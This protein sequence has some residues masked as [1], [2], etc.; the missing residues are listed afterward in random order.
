MRA[1]ISAWS[2]SGMRLEGTSPS[3]CTSIRIVSSTKSGLPSVFSSTR[4][5]HVG[6][7]LSLGEQCGDELLALGRRQRLELD[8]GRPQ[9]PAAPARPHVEQLGACEAD[10]QERRRAHPGGEV[11]DQLEERLLGPVDVLEHEHER[12]RLRE[13][14]GPLA[15]GPRDL[16]LAPLAADRLE[17]ARR[18]ARAGRRPP[19]PRRTRA[20]SRRPRP[21]GSSS[22]IPTAVLTISASGQYVIP[23]P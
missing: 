11:L 9:P 15:H 23:S 18:R 4:L 17:H 16:L 14:L 5:E 22:A 19:R 8:R 2:V 3:S 10:E 12:L 7:Q 20:A 6:G 13:L 1:A 21:A